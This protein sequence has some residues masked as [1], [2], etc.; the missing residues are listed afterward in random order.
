M[1]SRVEKNVVH[2]FVRCASCLFCN[3]SLDLS[4]HKINPLKCSS[5]IHR[6]INKYEYNS[7][8]QARWLRNECSNSSTRVCLLCEKVTERKSV[9]GLSDL[10]VSVIS[11]SLQN[12]FVLQILFEASIAFRHQNDNPLGN[13]HEI[14][15]CF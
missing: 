15:I 6:L 11:E 5:N 7:S 9:G 2:D 13:T 14:G 1:K 8:E 12:S 10:F 3:V 4:P